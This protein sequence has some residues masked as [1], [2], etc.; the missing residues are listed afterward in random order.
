MA[1]TTLAAVV[2]VPGVGKTTLSRTAALNMNYQHLNYGELM[3]ETAQDLEVAHELSEI[4]SLDLN[5][6]YKIWKKAADQAFRK[7][8][9]KNTLLDLHGLDLSSKGFLISLPWEILTPNIIFIIEA[10]PEEI[11]KRRTRD[12]NRKRVREDVTIIQ[13]NI[14]LLRQAMG[15]CSVLLGCTLTIIDNHDF[16]QSIN[17]IESVLKSL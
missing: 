11:L 15:V 7:I 12:V 13:H 3:L 6:Q 10:S 14:Q 2:G 1:T 16:N 5:L 4:F 9:T 17:M 8:K